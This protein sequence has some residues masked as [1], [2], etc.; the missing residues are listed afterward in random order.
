M[1]SYWAI[2]QVFSWDDILRE[3]EQSQVQGIPDTR[4]SCGYMAVFDN[5]ARALEVVGGREELLMELTHA[6]EKAPASGKR[7]ASC[8]RRLN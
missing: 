8:D 1:K 5:K 7:K 4:G 2:R 6:G 3:F